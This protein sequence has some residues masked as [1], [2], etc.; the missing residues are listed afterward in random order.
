MACN[1]KGFVKML[2]VLKLSVLAASGL[3]LSAA[4]VAQ[5]SNDAQSSSLADLV[6]FPQEGEL[7][8]DVRWH[9]N[10]LTLSEASVG[11]ERPA[12]SASTT[13]N[14]GHT[15]VEGIFALHPM[16]ALGAGGSLIWS[17]VAAPAFAFE[18]GP[19]PEPERAQSE[20]RR[21]GVGHN[22]YIAL[23]FNPIKDDASPLQLQARISAGHLI[24]PGVHLSHLAGPGEIPTTST[25]FGAQFAMGVKISPRMRVAA[26]LKGSQDV[27]SEEA[28]KTNLMS[29]MLVQVSVSPSIHLIAGGGYTGSWMK[30]LNRH[31]LS[32][33]GGLKLLAKDNMLLSVGGS[34]MPWAKLKGTERGD[35]FDNIKL[36]EWGLKA[37]LKIKI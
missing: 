5:L 15:Q 27:V 11:D 37:G 29:N 24:T 12:T 31:S 20:K 22:S 16:F 32:V 4:S 9:S 36:R 1:T 30:R 2:R 3:L 14:D 35:N 6:Y 26:S 33:T 10:W 18:P 19:V 17:S 28:N 23:L 21:T 7:V 13:L 34:Y 8:F 25:N